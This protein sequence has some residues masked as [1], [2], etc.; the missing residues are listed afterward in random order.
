MK[1]LLSILIFLLVPF[2]L[3]FANEIDLGKI[4]IIPY[5]TESKFDSPNLEI[6]EDKD[7]EKKD[8]FNLPTS[9]L[10]LNG[11]YITA[12]RFGSVSG[13]FIRGAQSKHTGYMLEG[14]KIY[15]PSNTSGYYVP[16]DF[17][18]SGLSQIEVFKN[19]VSTLYGSSPLSGAIN[20]LVKKPQDKPYIYLETTGGSHSTSYKIFEAGGK[21]DKYSYLLNIARIDTDG[22][23]KAKEKNNNSEKD[24]YQNTNLLLNLAYS[25]IQDL[26][27]GVIAKT[28]HSR[29]ELDDD[30]NYDGIPEDDLDN[31]GWNNEV[32]N[33]AYIKQRLNDNF[34]YKISLG[35][36]L[37]YRETK[38]DTEEYVRDWYRGETYQ[39][40]NSFEINYLEDSKS[41]LGFD[42][43]QEKVQSY[44]N[45]SGWETSLKETNNLKG[46][47]LEN[48]FN[49]SDSLKVDGS[50]RL[51]K[52][53]LFGYHSTGRG[54]LS[55]NI[56]IIDTK[57]YALYS[58][59]FKAPSIY[60]L[61]SLSGNRDLKPEKSNNWEVGFSKDFKDKFNISLS[62][63]HSDF[64]NLID[65]V[66]INPTTYQG[67]Y[68]NAGKG[69]SRGFETKLDWRIL[70]SLSLKIGYSF[71]EAKQDF[72]DSDIV[73]WVLVS[74]NIFNSSSIR[75]PKNKAF[76]NLDFKIDKL[77][78][79]F[80]LSYI[81]KRTDRIFKTV[82]FDS[83]DEFVILKPYILGNIYINYKLSSNTIIFLNVKNILNKDYETIKGYQEEK[84]SF[85]GGLKIKF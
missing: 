41:I 1:R 81:G 28:I 56:P 67:K 84:L 30:D 79:S 60:Q 29:T 9:F 68:L 54:G 26:E 77:D 57:I 45:Y 2:N 71:C 53:P 70:P 47:F 75:T 24:A 17:L 51:E 44:G 22:F 59:G 13:T 80:D 50:Y 5:R 7:L 39:F 55:Y 21:I 18:L 27:L 23:S 64:K 20:F 6:L 32:F 4:V 73:G 48:I 78:L 15:D 35:R 12:G 10:S 36:T 11:L 46:F 65:F 62:Y 49:F 34:G 38:D 66:Y 19:P 83:F 63:F 8:I 72:V 82:G 14:I 85:Y 40:L 43:V 31:I 3:S 33:I 52:N 61:Y 76:L 58:Q 42:Y 25:P 37:I 74:T 69:K 16:S